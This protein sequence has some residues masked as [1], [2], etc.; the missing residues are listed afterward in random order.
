MSLL[1]GIKEWFF[2][3]EYLEPQPSL[4]ALVAY[5]PVGDLA[6]LSAWVKHNIPYHRDLD[7][8]GNYDKLQNYNGADLTIRAR[9]G[10]CE[11]RGAIFSE[12]IRRWKGWS[13]GH[14]YFKFVDDKGAKKAHDIC[15]FVTPSGQ[16]GWMEN[17]PHFGTDKEMVKFYA[18]IGW[19][20]DAIHQVNDMGERI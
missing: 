8:N 14:A 16:H 6:A 4:D 15:W 12:V 19:K 17:A 10:D 3:K 2:P 1:K 20:I 13:S 11:S 7:E 5:L 9:R 18:G